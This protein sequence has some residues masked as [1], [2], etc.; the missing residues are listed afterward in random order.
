MVS[1]DAGQLIAKIDII[2]YAQGKIKSN[3][4]HQ[5]TIPM[6]NQR[7]CHMIHETCERYSNLCYSMYAR[8][9]SIQFQRSQTLIRGESAEI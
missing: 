5:T 1:D 4:R 8:T 7:H 9:I 2:A 6:S 3:I